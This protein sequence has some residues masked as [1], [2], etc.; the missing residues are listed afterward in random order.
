MSNRPGIV[1]AI[2]AKDFRL[3]SRDRFYFW[4]SIAGLVMYAILFWVLPDTVDETLRLGVSG[5]VGI[6]LEN[7]DLGATGN[8]AEEGITLVQ[9]ED[10]EMLRAAVESGDEVVVGLS[11]PT[12]LADPTIRVYVGSDVPPAVSSSVEGLAKELAYLVVGVP[13]PVSGFATEQ[14][15][16]GTDRAGDQVSL[17]DQFRPLLAF[18]IL[19]IESMALATL[20]AS[21]IQEKTVKAVT[22]TP[23]RVSDFLTA[24]TIFGTLLAFSQALILMIAIRSLGYSPVIL[25]IALLFGAALV[26]GV[27]M[28]VGS[29]GKDYV[30]V[31]FWSILFLV[32]FLVPAMAFMF[33]GSTAPWVQVIPS[34]P[35]AR[36]MVDVTNYEAGWAEVI[37]FLG[38]L[39]LWTLIFLVGG[40]KILER[41][42][43]TL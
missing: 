10:D 42:V 9:F 32:P 12:S 25:I 21:E 6:D 18:F 17:Q 20:V 15:I 1:R 33:P 35:L 16:L 14:I 11:L 24:K 8:S 36:I 28:F 3:F 37:P 31:I 2:I 5:P 30:G 23:A 41:R 13:S 26:T 39:A 34:Y 4:I 22:T 38:L 7:L 43:Q 19:M 27:G 40:W 29:V